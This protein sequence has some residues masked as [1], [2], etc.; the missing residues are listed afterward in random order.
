MVI[1]HSNRRGTKT[2]S[3][4]FVETRSDH[5]LGG[6]TL[7]HFDL[8]PGLRLLEQNHCVQSGDFTLYIQN[9]VNSSQKAKAARVSMGR[10]RLKENVE[11]I[12]NEI[13]LGLIKRRKKCWQIPCC[14]HSTPTTS[15]GRLHAYHNMA[16]LWGHYTMYKTDFK[17]SQSHV[18]GY[19]TLVVLLLSQNVADPGSKCWAIFSHSLSI[20]MADLRT[21]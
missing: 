17:R 9:S 15:S 20:S 13:L 12:C 21:L 14:Q 2:R 16:E 4:S 1:L 10:W 18:K 8:K 5:S 6:K 11:Y 7:L 19:L 3:F